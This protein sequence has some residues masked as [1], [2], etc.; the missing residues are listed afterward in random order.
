MAQKAST[1][2]SA[3]LIVTMR[4][5]K[6]RLLEAATEGLTF[7][8]AILRYGFYEEVVAGMNCDSGHCLRVGEN[9][10]PSEETLTVNYGDFHVAI[11]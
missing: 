4:L 5:E 9:T 11:H 6:V 3:M 1:Q 2:Q 7:V 8:I 10:V